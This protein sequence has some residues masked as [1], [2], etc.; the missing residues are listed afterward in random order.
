MS[1]PLSSTSSLRVC[2]FESRRADDMASLIRR[3]KGVPTVVPSMREIPLDENTSALSFGETLLAGEVDAVV[4]LTGVGADALLNLLESRFGWENV[5]RALK[6][7]QIVVRGP[8]PVSVLR[9]REVRIDHRA[10]EP[11][12]WREVVDVISSANL[13]NG[14]RIAIQEYGQPN[15][16]LQRE[17][18]RLGA[19]VTSV[20]IYRWAL[21]ED[22]APLA[23]AV[24]KTIAGEFDVL[25]FTSAQQ[26]VNVV[27]VAEREG[28][29]QPWLEATHQLVV[30]SIGPTCR[31]ALT[32]AGLNVDVEASPTKMGRLVTQTL[33]QAPQLLQ[34]KRQTS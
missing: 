34:Q 32:S 4:F 33:A 18:E 7:C 10:A 14:K 30:G 16:Q 26:V 27:T 22:C 19:E 17:L 5:S 31:E 21:P 6:Q 24:H 28:A 8:K 2:S 15:S 29:K 23:E 13:A 9:K 3:H 1:S 20:P 25:L 11:N 12:T